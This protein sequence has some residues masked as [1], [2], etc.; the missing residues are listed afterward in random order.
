MFRQ[1][2][3]E[4]HMN[5]AAD[6]IFGKSSKSFCIKICN[7][8][9]IHLVF[10]VEKTKI[11]LTSLKRYFLKDFKDNLVYKIACGGCNCNYF[12]L[13]VQFYEVLIR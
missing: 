10:T 12:N 5:H 4:K 11:F 1:Q 6:A 8:I 3:V 13:T 9:T 7:I 2:C